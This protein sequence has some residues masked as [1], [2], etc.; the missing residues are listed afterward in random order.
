[1][2]FNVDVATLATQLD[3]L[4]TLLKAATR[5]DVVETL[6]GLNPL[7]IFAPDNEAFR[8]VPAGI[9]DSL[10]NDKEQLNRVLTY[11]VV[12]GRYFAADLA[13]LK[14]ILTVQGGMLKVHKH[15]RLRHGIKINDAEVKE[16]NLECTNGVIHII[17]TVLM[18]K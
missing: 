11:H 10:L 16:A 17:D 4:S 18:P 5:A 15:H 9:L 7:T 8:K 1:L 2:K 13:K 12:S 3:E 14:T 6:L